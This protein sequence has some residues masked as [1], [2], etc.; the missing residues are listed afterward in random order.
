MAEKHVLPPLKV[1]S[2]LKAGDTKSQ[3]KSF[4]NS[5]SM[6]HL[7]DMK[8]ELLKINEKFYE[9]VAEINEIY[10]EMENIGDSDHILQTFCNIKINEKLENFHNDKALLGA[11]YIKKNE[12]KPFS[13]KKCRDLR[14]ILRFSMKDQI[15]KGFDKERYKEF[16]MHMEE[17]FQKHEKLVFLAFIKFHF[18]FVG[19]H[20]KTIK[21]TRYYCK[22]EKKETFYQRS[23]K[24]FKL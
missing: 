5:I 12:K 11:K 7:E 20:R 9:K 21:N 13:R 1:N 10:Q 14:E 19:N 3:A 17:N 16:A 18:C 23:N 4:L 6:S 2:P 24:I 22:R 15:K 8:S